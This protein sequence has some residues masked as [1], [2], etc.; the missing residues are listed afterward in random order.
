MLQGAGTR[1]LHNYIHNRKST[2]AEWAEFTAYFRGM[3]EGDGLQGE[4]G[5]IQEP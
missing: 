3:S 5:G 4:G 2:V 1:P